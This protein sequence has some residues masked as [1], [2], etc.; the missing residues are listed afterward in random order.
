MANFF[1]NY[2]ENFSGTPM[3]ITEKTPEKVTAAK[4]TNNIVFRNA[5]EGEKTGLQKVTF[6]DNDYGKHDIYLVV[7]ERESVGYGNIRGW[8]DNK[9]NMATTK[10][11]VDMITTPLKSTT[12][13]DPRGAGMMALPFA[14]PLDLLVGNTFNSNFNKNMRSEYTGED[15]AV[16]LGLDGESE[17]NILGYIDDSGIEH[18]AEQAMD[19]FKNPMEYGYIGINGENGFERPTRVQEHT[20]PA[21]VPGDIILGLLGLQPNRGAVGYTFKEPENHRDYQTFQRNLRRY[22]NKGW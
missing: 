22:L 1:D 9:D 13:I 15:K 7:P 5:N 6:L 2:R 10:G 11:T 19:L 20:G 16:G 21:Y 17:G 18:N 8:G 12:M 14:I 3:I 4:K